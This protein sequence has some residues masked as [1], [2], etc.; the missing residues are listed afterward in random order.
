MVEIDTSGKKV[1]EIVSQLHK[2]Y[3]EP[4]TELDNWENPIQ[5]MAS[6]ILSAQA[7]DKGVNKATP[8]LFAKYKTATD[9]ANA[10]IDELMKL[11]S[12]INFYRVKAQRIIDANKF[13]IENFGGELPADINKLVLIPGIGRKS[14]NV[15]MQEAL[16]VE[17]VGMVVDT[18][19][20]RLSN[21][22]GLQPYDNQKDAVKIEQKLMETFP[23]EEWRFL[24]QAMVLHGRYVCTAKKPKCSECVLNKLCPSAFKIPGAQ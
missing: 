7:T 21:R 3:E 2:V 15:I 5:F 13:V 23:Q 16:G 1:K 19:I 11:V 8:A 22:L 17:A 24:S 12:S 4:K 10:D 14:A 6:V 18:H 20:T 9:F